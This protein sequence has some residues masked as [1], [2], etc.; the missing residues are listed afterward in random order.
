MV[1]GAAEEGGAEVSGG[2]D[3][4]WVSA[5]RLS[6][7]ARVRAPVWRVSCET[8]VV[9]ARLGAYATSPPPPGAPGHHR[10]G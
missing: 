9:C 4:A 5:K 3:N 2:S 7:C 8:E 6:V 10:G 1:Q